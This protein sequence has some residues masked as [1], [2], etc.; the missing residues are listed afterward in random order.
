MKIIKLFESFDR[1]VK[2][3][4]S[5]DGDKYQI[6][7]KKLV[8]TWEL[9]YYI[10][11]GKSWSVTNVP[12]KG[13]IHKVID[14]VFGKYLNKFIKD[15]SPKEILIEGL[16]KDSEKEYVSQRTKAYLRYLRKNTPTGWDL[17]PKGDPR[18]NIIKL[19]YIGNEAKS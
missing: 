1:E 18:N 6:E 2:Y 10:W 11:D 17:S 12:S 4:F 8:D 7:F 3:D 15:Q 16:P 13:N 14:M 9:L 5:I 19:R